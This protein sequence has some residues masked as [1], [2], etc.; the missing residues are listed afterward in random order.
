MCSTYTHT[1][2][3][4]HGNYTHLSSLPLR[5]TDAVVT[6]SVCRSS[7]PKTLDF[8]LPLRLGSVLQRGRKSSLSCVWRGGRLRSS[9]GD[10]DASTESCVSELARSRRHGEAERLVRR[11]VLLTPTA[12]LLLLLHCGCSSV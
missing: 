11:K 8:L 12:T 10:G 9:C 2:R 7:E 5:P 4:K 1:H 3:N 6:F